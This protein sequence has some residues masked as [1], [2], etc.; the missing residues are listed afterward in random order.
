MQDSYQMLYV[1]M[2][3]LFWHKARAVTVGW[4]ADRT[5][6]YHSKWYSESQPPNLMFNLH[7][8][9]IIYKCARGPPNKNLV[10]CG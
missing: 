7:G 6:K 8:T 2:S 10:G 9:A 5:R 4:S 3:K 1:G